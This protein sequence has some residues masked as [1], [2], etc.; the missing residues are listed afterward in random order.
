M[1]I[2]IWLFVVLNVLLSLS[3]TYA[4]APIKIMTIGDSI[5]AA[6]WYRRALK[7]DLTAAGYRTDFVG[8]QFGA[9]PEG[10][11]RDGE[12]EGYPGCKIGDVTQKLTDPK[13]GAL[14]KFQ[15]DF[16][17]VLLGTNDIG[18]G[19]LNGAIE[20]LESLLKILTKA[21]PKAKIIL[22]EIPS[23]LPH[24]FSGYANFSG[25]VSLYNQQIRQLALRLKLPVAQIY[26][27]LP[28]TKDYIGDGV[29]PSGYGVGA[30]NDGYKRLGD[31]WFAAMRPLLP[32]QAP[33]E[34]PTLTRGEVVLGSDNH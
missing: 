25:D 3:A 13:T 2:R 10:G 28:P 1:Q 30:T 12:H 29:H 7:N 27:S 26:R 9:N 34:N 19:Q 22:G 20:R 21:Q 11:F 23:I 15:P 6:P 16:I 31:A 4:Q 17:L 14:A 24:A 5:T 18:Q 33:V 32:R 8:T